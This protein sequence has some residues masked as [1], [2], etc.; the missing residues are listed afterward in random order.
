MSFAR[1]L[2]RRLQCSNP[3]LDGVVV[4]PTYGT[5]RDGG[6][7]FDQ[8]LFNNT[9][10]TVVRS[11]RLPT[12]DTY[13]LTYR[14]TWLI[15]TSLDF[16]ERPAQNCNWS[17]IETL[18]WHLDKNPDWNDRD[19]LFDI[20]DTCIKNG[21][22]YS[23]VTKLCLSQVLRYKMDEFFLKPWFSCGVFR[24]ICLRHSSVG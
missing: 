5:Y 15:V 4:N 12:S 6:E 2:R 13:Q 16:F 22:Q 10:N 17:A 9:V 20:H 7:P 19:K 1:E 3:V 18:I 21:N 11:V 14:L 8:A 24:P 23:I